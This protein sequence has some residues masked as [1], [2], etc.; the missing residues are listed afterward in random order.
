M[1]KV[2]YL[3]ILQYVILTVCFMSAYSQE[4]MQ[5]RLKQHVYVLAS[6]SLMGRKAGSEYSKK[7]ADY[8]TAQW[9][10][11]GITPLTGGSYI[12]S[13]QRS[14]NQYHNIVGIIEG[15]DPVLKNEYIVVG[16]HYDH[17]GNKT[18]N[19]EIVIYNGADDNASGVAAITELGRNLKATQ[20]DLR[21]SVILIAFDA[22]EIGLYGSYEFAKNPPFNIEKIKLMLSVDMVGWHSTSGYVEYEGSKTIKNGNNF[23]LDS[24][25]IPEGL[26]VKTKKFE[27]SVLTATDTEGFAKKGI[28]TLAVT[29]GLKSPYHKPEDEAH[30]IDYEGLT[31][32]TEHL[33][34]VVKAASQDETFKASGKIAS[35]HNINKKFVFV[36]AANIGSN[37]HYYTKG[38][39]DGKPQTSY[40]LGVNGQFNMNFFAIRP[41]VYY[42]KIGACHPQGDIF[43]QNIT[44]PLNFMLQTPDFEMI[45]AAFFIGPYYSYRFD[46]KQSKKNIDFKNDF[47][48]DE[49][50]LNWGFDLRVAKIRYGLTVRRSFTNFTQTKNENGAYIRNRATFFNLAYLF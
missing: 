22:E 20:S 37:S 46:G 4:T 24:N 32:V 10:E 17:L 1:K 44:I 28:P 26:N 39:L 18:R 21:R 7:A 43:T 15:N 47:C 33:T 49:I 3:F 25:K 19:G 27:N 31:L 12:K 34:N 11:I 2:S 41:E 48:R 40:S 35:K 23:L 16:A 45:G 50:G 29:T 36:V 8:I 9:K 30:L 14:Q 42:E 6:D 13:F 5:E 38:A